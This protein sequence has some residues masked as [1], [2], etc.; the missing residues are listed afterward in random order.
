M[1]IVTASNGKR[2]LK[3]SRKEWENIWKK[4]GWTK[5]A[6]ENQKFNKWGVIEL[7]TRQ[8]LKFHIGYVKGEGA[9]DDGYEIYFPD[10]DLKKAEKYGIYD[11]VL[12]L[13]D[14]VQL[15][16]KIYNE[17]QNKMFNT[18]YEA[19]NFVKNISGSNLQPSQQTSSS[20]GKKTL[21]MSRKELENIGKKAGWSENSPRV[22]SPLFQSVRN[23]PVQNQPAKPTQHSVKNNIESIM[24]QDPKQIADYIKQ[25]IPNLLTDRNFLR[26]IEAC[27]T[28]DRD[29]F[30]RLPNEYKI[31][32]LPQDEALRLKELL[33]I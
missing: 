4:A 23:Q 19:F 22:D 9:F 3:I 20:N 26:A 1:K 24:R 32:S 27:I 16:D 17:L 14:D 31:Y 8:K 13:N 11:K 21:K 10:I 29:L 18:I 7:F 12:T 25:N 33:G 15:L 6:L 30:D 5:T 28:E 2:I